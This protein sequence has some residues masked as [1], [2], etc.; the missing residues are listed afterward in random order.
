[1]RFCLREVIVEDVFG[2][3]LKVYAPTGEMVAEHPIRLFDRGIRP[4]HPEHGQINQGYQER[5]EA[6]RT[7]L[8]RQFIKTFPE[9]GQIYIEGLKK[10]VGANLYWHL[11]EIVRYT[12]L[13]RVGEIGEALSACI[14]IGAY[15]KN[16]VKR[17]LEQREIKKPY[18]DTGVMPPLSV[19]VPIERSLS[20]YRVEVDHA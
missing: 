18:I 12:V 5:K 3:H 1:M 20:A 14:K 15:H 17:L 4:E 16:S 19:S 10:T 6:R 2:R 7:L 8:I 11:E 13:Y 9:Q